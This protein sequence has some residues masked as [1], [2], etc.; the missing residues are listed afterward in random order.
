MHEQH[1]RACK[2]SDRCLQQ[3]CDQKYRS[4]EDDSFN[5]VPVVYGYMMSHPPRKK[6]GRE[7][8]HSYHYIAANER[9]PGACRTVRHPR[10]IVRP[11]WRSCRLRALPL[12]RLGQRAIDVFG[13]GAQL[14]REIVEVGE[15]GRRSSRVGE[16]NRTAQN[17]LCRFVGDSLR[18]H[19]LHGHAFSSRER[20][21]F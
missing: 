3:A 4:A 10:G 5:A 13:L 20:E 21:R 15:R 8:T 19:R 14:T 2:L 18:L 6:H 16:F 11:I 12:E 7:C 17:A 9:E 1:E